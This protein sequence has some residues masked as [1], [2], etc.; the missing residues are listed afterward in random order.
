M[1]ISTIF[2]IST[3]LDAPNHSRKILLLT[4]TPPVSRRRTKKS[5]CVH[6]FCILSRTSGSGV[7]TMAQRAL[8]KGAISFGLVYIPVQMFTAASTHD[9]N[10][11]MVDKRDISPKGYLRIILITVI[12]VSWYNIF[13]TYEY[14]KGHYVALTYED[15]RRANAKAT[16]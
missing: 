15:L 2:V 5:A 3:H 7:T 6:E 11:T 9:L 1:E 10:L 14:V 12:E 4:R 8:W 16:R 13:M